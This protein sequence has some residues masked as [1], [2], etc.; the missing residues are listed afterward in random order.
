MTVSGTALLAIS[1]SPSVD[2]VTI[3]TSAQE[4]KVVDHW[5]NGN[6]DVR[7]FSYFSWGTFLS[8]ELS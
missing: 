4:Q 1:G 2:G 7:N 6:T 5:A 8:W 3:D